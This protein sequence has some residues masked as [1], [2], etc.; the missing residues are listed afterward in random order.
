TQKQRD[1]HY[2]P[3]VPPQGLQANTA[4]SSPAP[5][6][7]VDADFHS[8]VFQG[9]NKVFSGKKGIPGIGRVKLLRACARAGLYRLV[10]PE[11]CSI[12]SARFRQPTSGITPSAFFDDG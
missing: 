12:D 4:T 3:P 7:R 9:F 11:I 10:V 1:S 8:L 2:F 6:R 5:T